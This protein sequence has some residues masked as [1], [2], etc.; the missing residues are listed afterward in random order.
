MHTAKGTGGQASVLPE[1]GPAPA[2]QR[3]RSLGL[4]GCFLLNKTR[5]HDTRVDPQG[6][7]P[8]VWPPMLRVW[9]GPRGPRLACL[10]VQLRWWKVTE[11]WAW[12]AESRD[13]SR[14]RAGLVLTGSRRPGALAQGSRE[15]TLLDDSLPGDV[16]D[17]EH[18]VE[19]V[20]GR[21]NAR[22][23]GAVA[24]RGTDPPPPTSRGATSSGHPGKRKNP[25]SEE[26]M[27]LRGPAVRATA[28][29]LQTVS[30]PG[31]TGFSV[32]VST[33]TQS[34]RTHCVRHK[35]KLTADPG[36][37]SRQET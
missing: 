20:A 36:C 23:V 6:H 27:T 5:T 14:G 32:W 12:R 15:H 1:A 21:E 17:G 26:I 35:N 24:A 8:L 31:S 18:G 7:A 10:R 2:S 22:H 29:N 13:F 19:Y 33:E 28:P 25:P 9:W 3:P 37:S 16:R 11:T 34:H 30:V 4:A